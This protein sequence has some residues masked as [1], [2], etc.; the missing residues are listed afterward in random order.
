MNNPTKMMK[1]TI[2]SLYNVVV[3]R[4]WLS[5]TV[6]HLTQ[7]TCLQQGCRRDNTDN[8]HTYYEYTLKLPSLFTALLFWTFHTKSHNMKA[9]V[10]LSH[11]WSPF[12]PVICLYE[13][14]E[15]VCLCAALWSILLRKIS[16]WI[17]HANQM[18]MTTSW[19]F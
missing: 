15:L 9:L 4:Y 3:I 10:I 1:W 8:V 6:W 12:L 13:K 2:S 18:N 7:A 5:N 11:S 16:P 14:K 17:T 19:Q